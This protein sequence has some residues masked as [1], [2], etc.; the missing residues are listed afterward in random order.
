[1]TAR[2]RTAS[3]FLRI[4]CAV[5]LFSLGFAHQPV[6]AA[7]SDSYSEA[8]RLPDGTFADICSEG[9]HALGD[10]GKQPFAKPLC[11][12]CLL[13]ASVI[14]PPPDDETWLI[15][16]RALLENPLP[17]F[18]ALSGSTATERPK[19]RAPPFVF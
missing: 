19:S 5:V 10:H 11:E 18:F 13:S 15:G 9:G 12:V 7:P 2:F 17:Q 1:M 16:E 8:Y 6:Q 4:F 14:L 3:N